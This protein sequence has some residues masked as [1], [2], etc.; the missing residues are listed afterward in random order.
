[1]A[2][3]EGAE[4]TEEELKA[5]DEEVEAEGSRAGAEAEVEVGVEE[6]LNRDLPNSASSNKVKSRLKKV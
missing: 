5:A 1:M 2:S 6:W 4:A 3:K